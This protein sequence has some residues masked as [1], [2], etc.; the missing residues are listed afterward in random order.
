MEVLCLFR[1]R[2]WEM[3]EIINFNNTYRLLLKFCD[4]AE[5]HNGG[6]SKS[7]RVTKLSLVSF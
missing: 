2:A 3:Y 7:M 5:Y 1:H 6:S 4:W